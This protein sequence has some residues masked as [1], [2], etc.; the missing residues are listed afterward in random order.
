MKIERQKNLFPNTVRLADAEAG[1]VCDT[2]TGLV[3]KVQ[4]ARLLMNSTM[5]ADVVHR[6]DCLVVLPT[7]GKLTVMNGM[8]AIT[9]LKAALSVKD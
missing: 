7:E 8:T 9:V 5:I 2:P 3:I 6:G 1:D 4:P